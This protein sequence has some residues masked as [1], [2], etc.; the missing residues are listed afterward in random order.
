MKSLTT[1]TNVKKTF[2]A[3]ILKSPI[4]LSEYITLETDHNQGMKKFLNEVKNTQYHELYWI[5]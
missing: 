1:D 2:M 3:W 4:I 5:Q